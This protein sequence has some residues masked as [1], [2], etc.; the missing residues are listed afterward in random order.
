MTTRDRFIR[1]AA[2][3]GIP[4]DTV[5]KSNG[6]WIVTYMVGATQ[7]Q[8]DAGAAFIAAFDASPAAQAAWEGNK[9]ASQALATNAAFLALASPT[10][11][12][13]LAQTQALTRQNSVIIQLL[14]NQ[15]N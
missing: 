4:F 14:L 5:T 12:Q 1:T 6:S 2:Q 15:L 13:V 10:A 8:K 7:A 9:Q 3:Q 11:A